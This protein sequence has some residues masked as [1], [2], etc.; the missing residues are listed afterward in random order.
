MKNIFLATVLLLSCSLS[1]GEI[2]SIDFTRGPH[3]A[4]LQNEGH[5]F[6][7]LNGSLYL[8]LDINSFIIFEKMIGGM[9]HKKQIDFK[10]V[11]I[12]SISAWPFK[13]GDN[14]D[15]YNS[16]SSKI[17][18][19]SVGEKVVFKL[20][21]SPFF[22][23]TSKDSYFYRSFNMVLAKE[24]EKEELEPSAE[25]NFNGVA[26]RGAD[27]K[28]KPSTFSSI[29]YETTKVI[30]EDLERLVEYHKKIS[31]N[32]NVEK[33][34]VKVGQLGKSK[35]IQIS[36]ARGIF[37]SFFLESSK[38]NYFHWIK[39]VDTET[40]SFKMFGDIIEG[41]YGSAILE[42]NMIMYLIVFYEKQFKAYPIWLSK[43]KDV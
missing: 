43:Y 12:N 10:E 11:S 34:I 7:T 8:G 33:L 30:T 31:P 29:K 24:F 3:K 17:E 20:I 5:V 42:H 41:S 36:N 22:D 27:I 2:I 18:Q 39:P 21:P 19:F 1:Y 15:F 25:N 6:L 32:Q 37:S 14:F 23:A 9:K 35:L 40:T 13:K 26:L 38:N 16:Y 4:S 28:L